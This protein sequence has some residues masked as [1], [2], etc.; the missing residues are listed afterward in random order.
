MVTVY[1]KASRR[2]ITPVLTHQGRRRRTC[3]HV[4]ACSS[5]Q[6]L[7]FNEFK[8]GS[9]IGRGTSTKGTYSQGQVIDAANSGAQKPD[10]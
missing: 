1:V 4:T 5:Y 9:C 2:S 7:R 8:G 10:S 6:T 3:T